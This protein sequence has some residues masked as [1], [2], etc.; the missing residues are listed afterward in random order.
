MLRVPCLLWGPC[1][2]G[3]ATPSGLPALGSHWPFPGMSGNRGPAGAP[4]SWQGLCPVSRWR[5]YLLNLY[6]RAM[7]LDVGSWVGT[8]PVFH[9]CAG[10]QPPARQ[11]GTQ[12]EDVWAALEGI[13]FSG[14]RQKKAHE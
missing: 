7:E 11:P 8:L 1:L 13:S 6:R 4:S 2:A 12:P 5:D 10:P 9:L 3:P 14:F